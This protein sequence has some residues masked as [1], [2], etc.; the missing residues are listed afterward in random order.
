MDKELALKLSAEIGIDVQQ[1]IREEAE[2]IFLRGLFES[3]VSDKLV[4]K[5]GTALR[6]IYASPR[7]SE[8][9][10]F[11]VTKK[12]E[13]NEFK[14]VIINITKSDDRFSIKDLWSKYYTNLAEIKIKESW[15]ERPFSMKIEVSKRIVKKNESAY[16][17]AISKSPTTNILVI[18]KTLTLEEMLEE[19]FQMIKERKMPGDIFD[20]WFI[21]QKLNKPFTL[22][23]FGY[24]KGKIIQEL[25]KFLPKKLY[26]VVENLEKLN[27]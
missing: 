15:Q 11:S 21:C 12:I 24:P 14:K 6:L 3:S 7:F 5:G 22:K 19:K 26:P 1:V 9:M 2:L 18:T 25:R 20:I 27:A 4:F 23:T 17:N 8:D 13:S 16:M 10:D